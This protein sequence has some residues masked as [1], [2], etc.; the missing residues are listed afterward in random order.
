RARG[1]VRVQIEY[2]VNRETTTLQ[3][4]ARIVNG[5][6]SLNERLSQSVR[7]AIAQ[8]TGTVH[9]YTLFTGYYRA[10]MRGEMRS[11]EVLGDR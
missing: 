4:K 11:F 3:F 1:V 10:R 6:W 5:R 7:N 2:V 8:R 9:S